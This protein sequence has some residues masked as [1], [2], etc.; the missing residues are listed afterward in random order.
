MNSGNMARLGLSACLLVAGSVLA[1]PGGTGVTPD[2]KLGTHRAVQ[3]LGTSA[4]VQVFE[5]DGRAERLYG[6]AFSHGATPEASAEAFLD[7]NLDLVGVVDRADLVAVPLHEGG[8]LLQPVMYDRATDSYKFTAMY[9]QQVREGVPVF[10]SR[11]TMLVRNEAGFPL[12]L[13]GTGTR[14]IG[15]YK[16]NDALLARLADDAAQ[17]AILDRFSALS[18]HGSAAPRVT[19][20][21]RVIWAG[22]GDDFVEPRLA[23]VS[24][25]RNEVDEWLIV[26]DLE[27]G[28]VL[29][30]EQTICFAD[31]AGNVSGLVTEGLGAD[32]CEE[33]VP[34]P[35]QWLRVTAG[36]QEA[37]TDASGDY[38]ITGLGGGSVTVSA[39]LTGLWFDV[40]NYQG[41]EDTESTSATPPGPGDLVFNEPNSD[42]LIRA[43]ANGYYWS[44][45]VRDVSI[46]ANPSYPT[47]GGSGFPCTVNRTDGFCPGNAWYD[48]GAQSINFCST[49][50]GYPNTAW[51]SV[52][53]HEYG[54]HLVNAGGSGQ[55]QYGE[56]A[57]DCMST[58]ILDS[59]LLGVGFFGSCSGSLRDADNSIQYPCSGG[60]HDCGQL[61]SGCIWETRNELV[62]TE[63]SDYIQILA[64]LFVN[65]IL[66]HD[67]SSITPS[68]TID[69]LTLDDDN[70]NILDGTPHYTEIATGFG[71]HNM[72]APDLALL[73]FEFPDGRPDLVSPAGTTTLRVNVADVSATAEP[74]TGIMYV[75]VGGV[76][77]PYPMAQGAPN[78][79][80]AIFPSADCGA[81][82][83]YY[84]TAETTSGSSQFWPAGAPANRYSAV[85]AT[86]IS[87]A[88][89]DDFELDNGWTVSGDAST[90]HW[91]RAVPSGGG[92]RGDPPTDDDG[93]G[94]CYV[95]QDGPGDTDIDGGTTVLTSPVLDASDPNTFV[96]Y[97][98]WY[99]NTFGSDPENDTFIVEVSDNGGVTWANLETVGPS[100]PEVN[101]GWFRVEY[102]LAGVIDTNDQFRIRFIASDLASGSVVEAGVDGFGLKVFTCDAGC[103][104]DFDGD[105]TVDFDDLLSLLANW[106]PCVGCPEDIDGN[107]LVDF[108]DLLLLLSTW[109]PCS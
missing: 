50:G 89:Q 79:Y 91:E 53:L 100:G 10:R 107:D 87:F 97:S 56:G 51:S 13:A 67:G 8:P 62:I 105:T 90:G 2:A 14:Q 27:T 34:T 102:P 88:F 4:R 63:P 18:V 80:T 5:R 98:R 101:G 49:G 82:L 1:G 30:E 17:Q 104:A 93:S 45:V 42:E 95:T 94:R 69:F 33:E 108:Q 103:A 70:G 7:G 41:A 44:N 25:V 83:G 38:V 31:L 60:I 106:G 78:E 48:P 39:G 37:F 36:G 26:T 58:I 66:L 24:T 57:G 59:N 52:V 77:T 73:A 3:V 21:E 81:A 76:T 43:Q 40:F 28:A 96:T 65:S 12:V 54:H 15:N 92:D 61:L 75:R 85:A 72:D 74:D 99:S 16:V 32:F 35:L 22:L 46:A 55:G 6:E 64:D 20:S 23:E 47:L 9:F 11:L 68:I 86:E 29:H 84:F 19:E 71:E 109:G